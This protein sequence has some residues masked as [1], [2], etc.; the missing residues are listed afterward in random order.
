MKVY[1]NKID[2][3]VREKCLVLGVILGVKLVRS[4]QK[5]IY[6]KTK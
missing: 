2:R 4:V 5:C 3:I 1:L 6:F